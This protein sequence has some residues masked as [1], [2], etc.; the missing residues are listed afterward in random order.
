MKT[1]TVFGAFLLI[2]AGFAN[3]QDIGQ[4]E[5][6]ING[7]GT[8]YTAGSPTLDG[9]C[10][11]AT[12][13]GDE[14]EADDN[15]GANGLGSII[16][17]LMNAG[18]YLISMFVDFEIDEAI[19]TFFNEYGDS[20][21]ALAAGQSWEIDEPGYLFG[22]IFDNFA[23]S[24]E[25]TGSLLDNSNGVPS[26]SDDDVSM[27]L[28]WDFTLEEGETGVVSFFLDDEQPD[29]GFWLSHTDPWSEYTYYFSSTLEI[30]GDEEPPTDV[31]APGTLLLLGSGLLGMG[32]ARR[33]RMRSQ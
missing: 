31:P 1:K 8:L 2:L 4:Y 22:N 26:G 28:G 30:R 3:A 5:A 6:C 19:N 33:R 25:T 21:G 9:A 27:A 15:I 17:T 18:D 16:I 11:D 24:N 12:P 10:E 14:A 32:L 23:D 13:V 7:N 20:G 29:S